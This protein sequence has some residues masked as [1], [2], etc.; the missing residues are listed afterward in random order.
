MTGSL[1]TELRSSS[2]RHYHARFTF[3]DATGQLGIALYTNK[4]AWE[5]RPSGEQVRKRLHVL[6]EHRLPISFGALQYA[7]QFTEFAT[8]REYLLLRD[9]FVA[10]VRGHRVVDFPETPTPRPSQKKFG[11]RIMG[12]TLGK[13]GHGRVFE[14]TNAKNKVVAIKI[15][16]DSNSQERADV[17]G[18]ID[19]NKLL[20]C[21]AKTKGDGGRILWQIEV[22]GKEDDDELVSVHKPIVKMTLHA[23]IGNDHSG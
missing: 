3:S 14:D 7:L 13:G 16:R 19:I 10:S 4:V 12:R 2:I 6:N 8:T 15:M 5:V 20:T 22:M 23:F 11:S 1:S 17:K 18:Q 21:L 9:D